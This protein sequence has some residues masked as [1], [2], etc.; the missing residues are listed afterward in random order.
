[1]VL[2]SESARFR[3]GE[4]IRAAVDARG[5]RVFEVE[6]DALLRDMGRRGGLILDREG[7]AA[8]MQSAL[9]PDAVLENMRVS[10]LLR[11]V[12][13]VSVRLQGMSIPLGPR[14]LR[15][16]L[17]HFAG[18][19]IPIEEMALTELLD[20]VSG[21]EVTAKGAPG[22]LDQAT[23]TAL[24][25]RGLAKYQRPERAPDPEAARRQA[26]QLQYEDVLVAVKQAERQVAG[27][28]D[29]A[30]RLYQA[31][32]DILAANNQLDVVPLLDLHV[33]MEQELE[34][35]NFRSLSMADRLASQMETRR[36]VFGDDA[37]NLLFSQDEAMV[38]YEI[39]RL[40]LEEDPALTRGQKVRRLSR[41]REALKVELAQ[42]GVYVSFPDEAP[43]APIRGAS[44]EAA[45][46][47]EGEAD[48]AEATAG[49]E[50]AEGAGAEPTEAVGRER[51][52]Q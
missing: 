25:G 26:F 45:E 47:F 12:R 6:L 15:R 37:S 27:T 13:R 9:G 33:Q 21:V 24:L 48:A 44:V 39:D 1:M 28:K 35:T 2:T 50:S 16:L 19:E 18:W 43:A 52:R 17:N 22:W 14:A 23:L 10:D 11:N 20:R 29:A 31:A 30:E 34:R 38:R 42:Q 41:R 8:A 49:A 40:A 36:R 32:Y 4:W 5:D 46:A 3:S 51:R 7:L